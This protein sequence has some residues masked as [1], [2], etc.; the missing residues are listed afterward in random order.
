MTTALSFM[1][2][3]AI[4]EKLLNMDYNKKRSAATRASTKGGR[5]TKISQQPTRERADALV[6]FHYQWNY[7]YIFK[8]K[9]LC[10]NSSVQKLKQFP[11]S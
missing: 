6:R 5:E 3:A 2:L 10:L 7:V 11:L 4:Q 9:I 1:L 8:Y